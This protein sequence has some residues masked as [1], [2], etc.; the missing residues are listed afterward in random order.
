MTYV[1]GCQFVPDSR[2]GAMRRERRCMVHNQAFRD[3]RTAGNDSYDRLAVQGALGA[4]ADTRK[5]CDMV[6]ALGPLP[7]PSGVPRCLEIG[8]GCSPYVGAL[9][10]AGWQ[11]AGLDISRGPS[12]FNAVYWGA[13]AIH[14]D[15]E[16]WACP[17]IF[18]L[19]LC[20]NALEYM[21]D[22]TA[23]IG[24][25]QELL[26]QNGRLILVVPGFQE[27]PEPA[28]FWNFDADTLVKTLRFGGLETVNVVAAGQDLY[29]LARKS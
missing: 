17:W 27:L 24:R 11:Y 15:F 18:G 26:D 4:L 28:H 25:M 21:R 8:C 13:H 22:A 2:T 7:R 1:C 3:P 10:M 16:G 12:H 20:V 23:A 6:K 19:I 5:V 29:A 9:R 14:S